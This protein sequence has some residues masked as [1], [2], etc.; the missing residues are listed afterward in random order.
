MNFFAAIM[1]KRR[2]AKKAAE[3]KATIMKM[4]KVIESLM[5]VKMQIVNKIG[6]FSG[7]HFKKGEEGEHGDKS[8]H[9]KKGGDKKF[10]KWGHKKG[11]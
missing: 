5:N 9:G 4:R 11:H 6:A 7:W 3:R 10:K 8:E 2:E 1:R